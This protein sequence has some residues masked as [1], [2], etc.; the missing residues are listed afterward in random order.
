[1]LSSFASFSHSS[2]DVSQKTF[3]ANP[4]SVTSVTSVRC[5]LL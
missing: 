2:P 3:T 1:M 5:F 4:L